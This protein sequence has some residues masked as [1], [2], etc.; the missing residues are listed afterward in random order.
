MNGAKLLTHWIF[1]NIVGSLNLFTIFSSKYSPT[2]DS[3]VYGEGYIYINCNI[4]IRY[5]DIPYILQLIW[6]LVE[7]VGVGQSEYLVSNMVDM[8]CLLLPPASGDELQGIKRGIVEQSDLIGQT[9]VSK[10]I[11]FKKFDYFNPWNKIPLGIWSLTLSIRKGRVGRREVH[12]KTNG[13][14]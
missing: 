6:F 5:S 4:Y 11:W 2:S 10:S 8:L 1:L 14:K 7:T 9:L 3:R 13:R 12:M